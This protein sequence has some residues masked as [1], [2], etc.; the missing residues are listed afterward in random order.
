MTITKLLI[1]EQ[2][3]Y[4]DIWAGKE[5]GAFLVVFKFTAIHIDQSRDVVLTFVPDPSSPDLD[6]FGVSQGGSKIE[7]LYGPT[8]GPWTAT[9]MG[10]VSSWTRLIIIV[11]LPDPLAKA[12]AYKI[13]LQI[14]ISNKPI[15]QGEA[16][17]KIGSP[18]DPANLIIVT[19]A[20]Q[21]LGKSVTMAPSSLMPSGFIFEQS[22]HD[23]VRLECPG[24]P[25]TR[26]TNLSG[27][28]T[29]KLTGTLPTGTQHNCLSPI[30]TIR[31][32]SSGLYGPV[33]IKILLLTPREGNFELVLMGFK[34]L[35][36]TYD[37][38]TET[39]GKGDEIFI[40][41]A[42]AKVDL[43]N[44]STTMLPNRDSKVFGDTWHRP[45]NEEK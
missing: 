4:Y 12:Q 9:A 30:Q 2:G 26:L 17:L 7:L 31:F 23:P 18:D 25:I 45:Q 41:I 37:T 38:L 6:M 3:F 10:P 8:Q 13:R 5:W 34:C 43:I 19:P 39:D 40:R 44:R 1:P 35:H 27:W 22:K 32:G 33:T 16:D 29:H 36:E 11:K 21:E 14:V 42:A 20:S 24:G 15:K 28:G